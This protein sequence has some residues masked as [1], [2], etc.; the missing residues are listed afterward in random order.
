M[1]ATPASSAENHIPQLVRLHLL[2][3]TGRTVREDTAGRRNLDEVSAELDGVT[4]RTPAVVRTIAD[5]LVGPQLHELG[6]HATDIGM[7]TGNSDTTGR[8]DAR[9]VDPAVVDRVAQRE[10]L[11]RRGP[12]IPHRR[13]AGLERAH[14]V[15]ETAHLHEL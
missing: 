8:N 9:T 12:D 6:F 15:H 4:G 2:A 10:H 11:L 3:G 1:L 7:P 13:E 14:R 5:A